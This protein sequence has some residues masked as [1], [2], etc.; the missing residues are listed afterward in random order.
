MINQEVKLFIVAVFLLIPSFAFAIPGAHDPVSGG[1]GFTCNSCHISGKTIGNRD[2][3]YTGNLC[4]TCHTTSN[5]ATQ[6]QFATNDFANPFKTTTIIQSNPVQSSHKWFGPDVVP[7]AGAQAP[8]D[9]RASGLNKGGAAGYGNYVSCGRCHAVH[10]TSGTQSATAPYLRMVNDS[11]QLCLNCHRSRDTKDH[12]LGTHPVNV[13]YTSA[14]VKAKIVS[15][16]FLAVPVVNNL[17]P[18]GQVKL[19]KSMVVCSTCHGVHNADSDSATYASYTSSKTI[20]NGSLLRVSPRGATANATNVCT[21]CHAGKFAH[22]GGSQNIQ[23]NDCHG[24]HV[25]YDASAPGEIKNVNLIRRYNTYSSSLGGFNKKR[26]LFRYTSAANR[27]YYNVAKTGVCQGCH[28]PTASHFI[29]GNEANGLVGSRV[30]C[31][32]CHRHNDVAGSFKASGCD[33]C[34]GFPPTAN[35]VGPGGKALGSY[36]V[37]ETATPHSKH[38]SGGGAN[39]SFACSQCHNGFDSGA[40]SLHQNGTIGDGEFVTTVTVTPGGNIAGAAASFAGGNCTAVYCHSNGTSTTVLGLPKTVTWAGGNGTI[41]GCAACHDAVPTTGSHDKHATTMGYGCATCH[42]AT[43]SNNTTLLASAKLSGGAHVNAVKDLQFS[44]VTPAVGSTCANVYCHSNGAGTYSSPTITDW[45]NKTNGACNSCHATAPTLAT[46]AHTTHYTVTGLSDNTVCIKCHTYNG[47]TAS[48]HVNGTRD[49][50][51]DSAGCAVNTCHGTITTPSWTG[52][53]TAVDTC[54]K[55]HGT[56]TQTVTSA[57]REVIA[58]VGGTLTGTGKVS[59]FAKVGAHETHLKYLNGFSNYSTVDYRCQACHGTLPTTGKHSNGVSTPVFQGLANLNGTFT[60]AYGATCSVYCHNPA[61]T[62]GKLA[63]A[64]AG[65]NTTPSWTSASY[66]ADG[67]KS[68]SNCEQCHKVPGSTSFAK[69]AAHGAMV[70]DSSADQCNSCHG[71]NGDSSGV[72]GQRHI[73]GIMYANGACDS[74][75]GYPP[76]TAA[77]LAARD[78]GTYVNAKLATAGGG[79]YHKKHLLPTIVVANEFTPCLPCHPSDALGFH[80]QGGGTVDSA[81]VN[82]FY[83]AD[84]GYRFDAARTKRFNSTDKTCSN[85]SC[86]FQ[87]TPA[88][89]L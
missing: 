89:N 8:I 82:V 31:A 66:L 70:T 73:D 34:H 45:A 67:G 52:N 61:G 49:V 47:E 37:D 40:P 21:N 33:G 50:N 78:A 17:N 12:T 7:A 60:T 44:N 28:N 24:G 51:Y 85:I 5:L 88:W 58:P 18:S 56:Q 59:N 32:N 25:E 69:A 42:A 53:Y 6:K 41:T 81:N 11:D 63:A 30:T 77:D 19:V 2:L 84:T 3:T 74:C 71:H 54:T 72:I 87:K 27:E 16:D 1:Y 48:P 86:H 43:A 35:N 62:G 46:G 83:A 26:V 10:G 79:G 38:A 9:T 75:H 29:S 15:G 55:C 23:C 68:L 39:Y 64:D 65:L 80:K 76:M 36:A 14:S 4:M 22:N 57:N 20:S 13:S